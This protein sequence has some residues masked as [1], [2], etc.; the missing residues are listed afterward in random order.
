VHT[1]T[2]ICYV[3]FAI[4]LFDA[5]A[6]DPHYRILRSIVPDTEAPDQEL[7]TDFKVERIKPD[8]N[9]QIYAPYLQVSEI[10]RVLV[11]EDEEGN[12]GPGFR[13]SDG[14]VSSSP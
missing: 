2:T 9:E 11:E 7:A 5:M 8:P 14:V 6:F 10:L 13:S 12:P 3:P 1:E 4:S